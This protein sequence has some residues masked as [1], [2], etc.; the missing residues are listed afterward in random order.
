MENDNKSKGI[1][2]YI[3]YEYDRSCYSFDFFSNNVANTFG[4]AY[5]VYNKPLND[6]TKNDFEEI[7]KMIAKEINKMINENTKK[8]YETLGK[9]DEYKYKDDIIKENNVII[10]NI[11]Q[12]KNEE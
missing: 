4:N 9:L 2:Y 10:I 11:I 12:L 6:F 7:T 3:V 5:L 8:S 1:K